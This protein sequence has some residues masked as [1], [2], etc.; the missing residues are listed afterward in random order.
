MCFTIHKRFKKAKIAEKD[1]PVLKGLDLHTSTFD[2]V[3]KWNNAYL[4]TPWMETPIT[5][6]EKMAVEDFSI[7]KSIVIKGF[8]E[9]HRGLHSIAPRVEFYPWSAYTFKAIIPKGARYYYNST[10]GDYVST[11]LIILPEMVFN[12]HNRGKK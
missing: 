2:G 8:E 11:E 1:I 5:F 6:N 9:I 12:Y 4:K 7:K 3:N 10:T